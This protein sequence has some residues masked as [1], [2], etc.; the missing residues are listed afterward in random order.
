MDMEVAEQRQNCGP[1]LYVY[2][3]QEEKLQSESNIRVRYLAVRKEI[4]IKWG[5]FAIYQFTVKEREVT[6]HW[7]EML[8]LEII[9]QE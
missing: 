6:A 1:E 3:I 7:R 9:L 5:H 2:E 8:A 4:P